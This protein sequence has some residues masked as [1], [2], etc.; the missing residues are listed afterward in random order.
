[1]NKVTGMF[2]LL[3]INMFVMS[4]SVAGAYSGELT[5]VSIRAIANGGFD[6]KTEEV[7]NPACTNDGSFFRVASGSNNMSDEGV[8]SALGVAML[9]TALDKKVIVYVDTSSLYCHA[10]LVEIQY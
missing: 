10:S 6:V 9:A 7:V 2:L 5:I 3:S 4:A 1:M 8:K